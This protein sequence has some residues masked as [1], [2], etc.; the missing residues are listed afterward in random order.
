MN[1]PL[2]LVTQRGH[3]PRGL[4]V[5]VVIVEIP[6]RAVDRA[7]AI[8]AA[9]GQHLHLGGMPLIHGHALAGVI[10]IQAADNGGARAQAGGVIGHAEVQRFEARAGLGDGE[11][12]GP[13][14]RRFD[15]T[16]QA[17]LFLKAHSRFDLGQQHIERIDIGGDADLGDQHGIEPPARL[18]DD[19]DHIAIHIMRV[20]AVDTH[21]HDLIA[22]VDIVQGLDNMSA[23]RG[24]VV[25]G[26]RVLAIQKDTVGRAVRGLFKQGG[27]GTGHGQLAALQA[28]GRRPVLGETHQG[29]LPGGIYRLR[30]RAGMLRRRADSP[31]R[32]RRRGRV[33]SGSPGLSWPFP[34]RLA[35]SGS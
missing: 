25:R 21:R 10:G 19:I 22:P 18:F 20:Q 1:R 14:E 13:A 6:K 26:D 7:Q 4:A 23:G 31:A 8:G 32:R 15:Q 2:A 30:L 29:L 17:D 16:F 11:H 28:R 27:A 12:I 9:G 35:A 5:G 33:Q 3:P 24:L 34:R